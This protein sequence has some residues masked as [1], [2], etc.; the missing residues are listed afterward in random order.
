MDIIRSLDFGLYRNI[1]IFEDEIS[2]AFN[3]FDLNHDNQVDLQ[4]FTG[5]LLHISGEKE[6]ICRDYASLF[7]SSVNADRDWK[8]SEIEFRTAVIDKLKCNDILSIIADLQFVRH[9]YESIPEEMRALKIIPSE[10]EEK[11]PTYV[12]SKQEPVFFDFEPIVYDEIEVH[13]P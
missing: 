13:R 10:S 4:E 9:V 8:M 7:I 5:V 6:S 3:L 2:A 11:K 1:Y 12:P